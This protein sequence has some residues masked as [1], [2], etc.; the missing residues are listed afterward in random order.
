MTFFYA[1]AG[2][3][4]HRAAAHLFRAAEGGAAY[5]F[6]FLLRP[7]E[8]WGGTS[9]PPAPRSG[10]S[11][12]FAPCRPTPRAPRRVCP[13]GRS[14]TRRIC[15]LLPFA[16]RDRGPKAARLFPPPAPGAAYPLRGR[17]G[18]RTRSPR[19]H[20]GGRR[21]CSSRA[22][23]V[24]RTCSALTRAAHL[25]PAFAPEGGAAIPFS[26]P[27]PRAEV[28]HGASVPPP[29]VPAR[30]ICSA[31]RPWRRACSSR[32]EPDVAYLFHSG[33]A[34]RLFLRRWQRDPVSSASAAN[35]VWLNRSPPRR[36]GTT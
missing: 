26:R 5:L 27:E 28:Q 11:V 3:L 13:L 18:W 30:R 14:R 1:A 9:V 34:V 2:G 24:R 29:G 8:R 6:L 10:A 35:R 16:T 7:P 19:P 17:P 25:F 4:D 12:S 21:I 15:S 32:P 22:K 31:A 20:R 23:P 36:R 33:G